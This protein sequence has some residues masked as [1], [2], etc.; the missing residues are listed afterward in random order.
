[1]GFAADPIVGASKP[2]KKKRQRKKG[3]GKGKTKRKDGRKLGTGELAA[4]AQAG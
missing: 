4:V 3:K 1:L 2:L